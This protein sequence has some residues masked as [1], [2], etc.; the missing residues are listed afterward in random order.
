[1]ATNVPG[2]VGSGG[3]HRAAAASTGKRSGLR[4]V[5]FLGFAVVAA[6]ATAV[7]LTRYLEARTAAVRVPTTKVVV[8]A[9]DLPAAAALRVESLKVVDWPTASLPERTSS[10]PSKLVG[11]VALN[12]I[13]KGEAILEGKLASS[14]AGSGLA[15]LLPTGMRAV[16]VRVDDVVGVAGFVH[17]GDHVDVIVTMKPVE[18][19]TAPTMSKIILQ[20]IRVLAVGKDVS[21]AGRAEKA[22]L[23]TVATLM[24]DSD[25]SER[26][27]LA[28]SKGQL[29]LALRSR[30]DRDEIATNGV[31]PPE[32]LAG[33][34]V[35]VITTIPVPAAPAPTLA[36][37]RPR[38]ASRKPVVQE[39]RQVERQTVEVIRGDLFEKRD[40]QKE[41]RQ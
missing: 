4:A 36:R 35:N 40:F 23:A 10:D 29:L 41:S 1:M 32:L 22:V 34:G 26:L 20:D 28:A 27:A 11:R 39:V 19:G 18:S 2:S 3:L 9:V 8:A 30:I 12:E 14:E 24:V 15:A 7:V 31:V 17:P 6:L 13:A 16:A 21:Q 37:T 33:E 38:P 5:L 25:Q